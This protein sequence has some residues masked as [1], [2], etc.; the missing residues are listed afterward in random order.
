MAVSIAAEHRARECLER[1]SPQCFGP[2]KNTEKHG[3]N[4]LRFAWALLTPWSTP[5]RSLGFSPGKLPRRTTPKAIFAVAVSVAAGHR[6]RKCFERS[7]PQC[8]GPRKN[9][10]KHGRNRHWFA[11]ALLKPWDKKPL[12]WALARASYHDE[13]HQRQC[14]LWQFPSRLDT[15]ARECFERSGPQCF[16]GGGVSQLP[17]LKP[18]LRFLSMPSWNG[19]WDKP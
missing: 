11:W 12:E 13:R 14:S 4:R 16:W 2:R 7:S 18:T 10:E 15:E 8:F 1:C 9:T 6:A 3:R 17:G 5:T 19:A